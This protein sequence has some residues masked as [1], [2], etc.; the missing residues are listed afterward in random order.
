[1]GGRLVNKS[2][3]QGWA[4]GGLTDKS[5]AGQR[6]PSRAAQEQS[7]QACRE[8]EGQ[9]DRRWTWRTW[10]PLSSKPRRRTLVLWP[11]AQEGCGLARPSLGKE[12]GGDRELCQ[13]AH[14]SGTGPG[15]TS[16]LSFWHP[17]LVCRDGSGPA[18]PARPFQAPLSILL[19]GALPSAC[20]PPGA[21]QAGDC[22]VPWRAD[23]HPNPKLASA[24][25][26]RLSGHEWA[27]KFPCPK[28]SLPAPP[29][30]SHDILGAWAPGEQ[31]SPRVA[32][33]HARG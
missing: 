28:Q 15:L 16:P 22:R 20:R 29:P 24:G 5:T 30:Q 13:A 33:S 6:Q 31:A 18:I 3:P 21:L 23:S 25:A 9:M 8:R 19:L 4:G 27:E 32:P 1:M 10:G 26:A 2:R 14:T 7:A 11:E 17:A 12:G